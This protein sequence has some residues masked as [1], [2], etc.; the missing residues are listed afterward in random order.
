MKE[1]VNLFKKHLL[2]VLEGL[3]VK[4][5]LGRELQ[6]CFSLQLMQYNTWV[7]DQESLVLFFRVHWKDQLG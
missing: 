7:Y 1:P 4:S 2:E 6:T 5:Y 3:E